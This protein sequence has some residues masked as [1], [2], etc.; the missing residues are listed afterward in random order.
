MQDLLS[1]TPSTQELP[2]QCAQLFVPGESGKCFIPFHIQALSILN[3]FTVC[4]ILLFLSASRPVSL[5]PAGMSLGIY[6][7][8]QPEG[9][10]R[11][12]VLM[13]PL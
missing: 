1:R 10:S 11:N 6:S 9:P 5:V 2:P 13:A 8:E 7:P 3:L 4:Q 12:K